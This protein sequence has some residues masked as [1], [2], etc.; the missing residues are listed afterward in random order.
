ML[1]VSNRS[2]AEY[3][4]NQEPML[5]LSKKQLVELSEICQ[6]LYKS[7]ENKFSGSGEQIVVTIVLIV[8]PPKKQHTNKSL[9]LISDLFFEAS[10]Q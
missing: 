10:N 6:D 3:N 7:I 1:L 9:L 8:I 2:L 5:I 4:L